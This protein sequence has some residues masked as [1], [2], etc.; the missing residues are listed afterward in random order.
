MVGILCEKPSAAR[1]FSK[2]LGGNSGI[3]NNEQYVIAS[4]VGHLFEFVEPKDMVSK[5]RSAY[6]AT[7]AL[8]NLPWNENDFLWKRVQKNNTSDISSKILSSFKDCDEVVIATDFDP[9]GEGDLLA[10]EIIQELNITPK[11]ISR[12]Y[13]QD[14]SISQIQKAFKD[15]KTITIDNPDYNK[16]L[17]RSKW[18]YMSMQFSRVASLLTGMTLREGRLKSGMA[19]IVG[20]GLKAVKE[21]KKVPFYQ[22]RFRDENGIV[23]ISENEPKEK[24]HPLS[25]KYESSAVIIDNTVNKSTAPPK[26]INLSTLSAQMAQTFGIKANDVLE[27]YQKM[28]QDQIVSYPRTEDTCITIEQYNELLPYANRIAQVVGVEPSLL[29]HDQRKTH[30]KKGMAHGANRPGTNIPKSLDYLDEKYG[31]GASKI[32]YILARSY[33]AML[34][35]DY[36]YDHQE[37]HLEK[38]PDFKGYTNKCTSMGWKAIYKDLSED[39]FS[40]SDTVLLGKNAEPF[41]HEG[42][43]KKPPTPTVKWLM[44]ELEKQN[45]GTGATRTST[46]AVIS[47]SKDKTALLKENKGKITLTEAGKLSYTLLQDTHIGSLDITKKVSDQMKLIADGSGDEKTYL[48]EIEKFVKE[49]MTIM[50]KNLKSVKDEFPDVKVSKE[51]VRGIYIPTGLSVSFNRVWSDHVFTTEEIERLLN[52]ETITFQSKTKK[53]KRY[54]AK[55]ALEEQ[56]YKGNTFWGF[57]LE[58]R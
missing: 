10:W 35:E 12:M 45:I 38:Y 34:C 20:D 6:Y 3:F 2:A 21:Y 53:G 51:K 39:D 18:D 30:I 19:V 54:L 26:L 44:K 16:A 49:D 7:W 5:D 29:T 41:E 57:S 15:R 22:W 36:T 58:K 56:E 33:L 40:D 55:G 32:Y 43:P 24:T 31:K 47:N 14:E 37:G 50:Q 13:F 9:S 1:N 42:F 25:K 4:S 17:F 46:F 23:Y 27:I 11:K 8:G 28:Y 48:K 52:G